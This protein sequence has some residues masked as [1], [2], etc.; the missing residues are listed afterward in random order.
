M[1]N[2]AQPN[3]NFNSLTTNLEEDLDCGNVPSYASSLWGTNKRDKKDYI[4]T[5]NKL[6][7]DSNKTFKS[8]IK[9]S[10]TKNFN[11]KRYKLN[12]DSVDYQTPPKNKETKLKFIE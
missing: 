9:L 1:N 12:F 5:N 6:H 3:F 4:L 2:P 11:S 8:I 7:S 10:N